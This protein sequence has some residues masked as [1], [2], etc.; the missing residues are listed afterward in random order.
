MFPSSDASLTG[1]L[2]LFRS[3]LH[4][5]VPVQLRSYFSGLL[6]RFF[7]PKSKNLKVV[8]DEKFKNKV[9]HAV[10]MYLRKKIEKD[11]SRE[12]ASTSGQ[13]TEAEALDDKGEEIL[14]SFENASPIIPQSDAEMRTELVFPDTSKHATHIKQISITLTP[15]TFVPR[16]AEH[17]PYATIA[18]EPEE[19]P[20][21][22]CLT[23]RCVWVSCGYAMQ[24]IR[25]KK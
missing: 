5:F 9:F 10:E 8:I 17:S 4:D 25:K 22:T 7:T 6:E 24:H 13:N 20:P 19:D 3:M 15:P 2:M 16:A 14:D 18:A 21:V 23:F 12:G 11:P 1:F